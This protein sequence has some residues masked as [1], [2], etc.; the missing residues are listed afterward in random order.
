MKPKLIETDLLVDGR[1]AASVKGN[2]LRKRIHKLP[3]PVEG[4]RITLRV[5]S[6][7]GHPNA[8]VFEVRAY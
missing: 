6:T 4:S 8:R 2:Y 5:L 1:V 3:E 7:S